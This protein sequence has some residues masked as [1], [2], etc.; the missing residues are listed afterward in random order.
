M[1]KMGLNFADLKKLKLRLT[2]I[3]V[4]NNMNPWEIKEQ[5]FDNIS[6]YANKIT[7]QKELER[8]NKSI[9]EIEKL[10]HKKRSNLAFQGMIAKIVQDLVN[11]GM[12][13]NDILLLN[14]F[15]KMVN[16]YGLKTKDLIE[17]IKWVR[18]QYGLQSQNV[19]VNEY[20]K[21]DNQSK[22]IVNI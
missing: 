6:Q 21:L 7:A 20:L 3:A 12:D 13:E 4:E 9:S 11:N 19:T 8:L 1:E 14:E 16:G 22:K 2:E 5:F 10:L 15:I 18:V 17:F